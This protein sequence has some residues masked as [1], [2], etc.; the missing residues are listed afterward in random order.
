MKKILNKLKSKELDVLFM[1]VV[2]VSILSL[3]ALITPNDELWNFANSYKMFNGYKIYEQLNVIITPLFFY[4]AQLFFEVFGP[5]MLSFRIYNIAIYTLFFVLIYMIFKTLK[6]TKKRAVFY[7]FFMIFIFNT[8]IPTGANYNIFAIIPILIAILLIIKEKDN[9]FYIGILL[10][11]TFMLKQNVFAFFAIGIFAYELVKQK[12]VINIFRNLFQIYLVAFSGIIIFLFY[13]YLENNL[14]NFINYCFLGIREF[15]TNN[16]NIEISGARYLYISI[17]VII[18]TFAMIY[19]KKINNKIDNKVI[20]DIKYLLSFG[21]PLIFT[22]LPIVNYYHA[23]LASTIIIIEFVYIIEK[24]LIENIEI[25]REKV[26][27]IIIIVAYIIYLFVSLR[28]TLSKEE[29]VINEYG[30]FKQSMI[31][32][33]DDEDIKIICEYIKEQ[34]NKNIEVKILSYKANAY[35]VNLNKNNGILDLAFLGNLG[36]GGEKE[37]INQIR[38]LDNTIILIQTNEEEMFWQESKLAREFI[39]NSYE[40]KGEIQG[41]SIYYIT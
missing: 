14:Y 22:A 23:T 19:N 20:L 4:I 8:M 9:P 30:V 31:T 21:L 38:K 24:I 28:V 12:D 2:I 11:L 5:T 32:K 3:G 36:I 33:E 15:G 6:I 10:F 1:I 41:Y 18:L 40:K 16:L 7:T 27:Y 26:M 17:M 35:M 13:M 34:N 25:K 37:L 29:F 39:I